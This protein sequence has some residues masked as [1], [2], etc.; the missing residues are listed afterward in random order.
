VSF[1]LPVTAFALLAFAANSLLARLA[2]G[3]AHIDPN[4]FTAVRLL[5]GAGVL[6]LAH[7]LRGRSAAVTDRSWR[8]AMA[9]FAYAITFSFAYVRLSAGTGALLLFGTVQATMLLAAVRSGERPRA[10]EWLGLIVALAGLAV[11]AAPGLSA[12]P[13]DAALLMGAAGVSWG[14][15]SVRGRQAADPIGDTSRNF[16][17]AVPLAA[18]AW[19]GLP[20]D[21]YVSA[22]GLV[23]AAVSGALA[24]ALG[25][26]A[27]YAALARLTTTRAA[28]VQLAVPV[29]AAAAG[30][31]VLSEPVTARLVTATVL[32]IGGIGLVIVSR[33]GTGRAGTGSR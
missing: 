18:V 29:L 26:I 6:A 31:A 11:L 4:S 16:I 8:S 24:S 20:G 7:G 33:T 2:L 12:P 25:Y 1:T 23:L 3:G 5:A 17:R 32:V 19:I 15:Y 9:L 22:P 10:T 27:W 14:L 30:V 13:W 21:A 28:A